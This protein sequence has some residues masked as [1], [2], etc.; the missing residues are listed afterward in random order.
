MPHLEHMPPSPENTT[1]EE[2]PK[3]QTEK[4]LQTIADF[5]TIYNENEERAIDEAYEYLVKKFANVKK[6]SRWGLM[7]FNHSV[8]STED[9]LMFILLRDVPDN[10]QEVSEAFTN[11]MQGE[12]LSDAAEHIIKERLQ[13]LFEQNSPKTQH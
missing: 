3:E 9:D 6:G 1:P 2:T 8:G 10:D 13:L 5:Q 11:L 12:Q 7:E 4:Q